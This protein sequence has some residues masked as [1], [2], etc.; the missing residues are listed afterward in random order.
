MSGESM[1]KYALKKLI[2]KNFF[3]GRVGTYHNFLKEC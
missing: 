3:R 1:G 2:G